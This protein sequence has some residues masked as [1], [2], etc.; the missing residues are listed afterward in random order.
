MQNLDYDRLVSTLDQLIDE[1]GEDE[2]HPL[3]S[4]MEVIGVLIEKYEDEHVPELDES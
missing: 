1:V 3:A 4:L 2:S